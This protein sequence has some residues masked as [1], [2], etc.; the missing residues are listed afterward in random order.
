MIHR[1]LS[2]KILEMAEHYPVITL[3]GPRQ[4]G[5]TTL[6]RALF[7]FFTYANLEDPESRTLARDD[8]K[9]FFETFPEP[10]IV[11]EVQHVPELLSHIQVRVDADRRRTGR[12][13]LTGS[14]QPRLKEAVSQSLAGRTAELELMPLSLEELAGRTGTV[15]TDEILLRGFFPDAWESGVPPTDFQRNYFRTYVE[16]DVRTLLEVRNRAAFEKFLH[17]LAGRIGQLVNLDGLAGEVGVSA[18]TIENWISV[19]EASFI[20]FRLR[21]WFA[22]IGK[23]FVK[24]PKIY[25]TDVGLASYLLGIETTTQLARDPLRGNLFENMVIADLVKNRTNIGRDPALFFVRDS[26][27]F[28]VDALYAIGRDLR[29]LEIKSARTFDS[30]FAKNLIAFRR[31][32]QDCAHPAIIYDGEPYADRLGVR[33]LPFRSLSRQTLFAEVS[34]SGE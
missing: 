13:L 15:P 29:P 19:A 14:H 21:P 7:P 32:V 30:S 31:L 3:L 8:P 10:L 33:C 25:F 18:P 28:E 1:L 17:L 24:T 5:K 4:S 6:A 22:N 11:D 34:S 12:F 16:R 9:T 23:R 2:A 20:V 26:K 27:G